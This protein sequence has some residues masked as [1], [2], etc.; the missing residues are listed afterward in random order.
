M[1][2]RARARRPRRRPARRNRRSG[3]N[4]KSMNAQNQH[5]SVI[6][7]V[8]YEDLS[9]NTGYGAVFTL[10]DFT[11]APVVATQYRWFRA[12]K[13]EWIYQP[14]YNTFQ[15]QATDS[16][17]VIPHI[18]SIM[19]RN[20]TFTTSGSIG[21]PV[22]TK[23]LLEEMGAKPIKFTKDI[24]IS[25]KP[26][27]CMPGLQA[28]TFNTEGPPNYHIGSRSLG[29]TTSTKWLSTAGLGFNT[30]GA[31]TQV[32]NTQEIAAVVPPENSNLG[33]YVQTNGIAGST[34]I[35][36]NTPGDVVYNGHLF[37]IEQSDTVA[38]SSQSIGRLTARVHWEF[39]QPSVAYVKQP[40]NI[41][42]Y[43]PPGNPM[44]ML[45]LK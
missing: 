20:Q 29:M 6:E 1:P 11:R 25:Y 44:R 12:K 37:Y 19:N 32:V 3:A 41:T 27:W 39:K 10:N 34:V 8:D 22:I 35:A 9:G 31:G 21:T 30:A 5:A 14:Y 43:V 7:T 24:T 26:N 38:P 17:A 18:L 28:A 23:Q 33:P 45:T 2:R 40:Q 16:G 42:G 4:S 15:E 36:G 13:V